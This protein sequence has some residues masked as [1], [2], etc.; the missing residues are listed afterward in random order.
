LRTLLQG[1]REAGI[2]A[3]DMPPRALFAVL[4]LMVPALAR[5]ATPVPYKVPFAIPNAVDLSALADVKVQGW[6]GGRI[7]A[8][9]RGRLLVVDT[10]PLLAGYIKKPGEQPW[11]G[12]HVGKWIDAA[13]LSWAYD[14]N[15]KMKEKLDGVVAQLLATQEADGYLG[16]YIPTQRFGLYDGADWDVWT[17]AYNMIGLMTYY[18]YTGDEAALTAVRRMGDLLVAT[19]PARKSIVAA[20]THEG[21][22]ATSVLE[23][24]VELYRLTGDARYLAFA[25]YIVGAYDEPGGPGIVRSLLAGRGV[26]RTANGKAYEMLANLMGICDMARVTGDRR[27]LEAVANAWTDITRNRLYVTGTASIFEHFSQDHEL[28]NTADDQLGETCVTTTWIQLNL[29]LLEVTGSAAY[30]DEVE[31]SLY[32]HLAAAQNPRGDDWCYYTPLEGRKRYDSGITCCHSSGPRALALAPEAAYL[33]GDGVICVNTLETSSVHAHP[34]GADVELTQASGFPRS[35]QSA[36]TIH[37]VVPARFALRIRVPGWAAPLQ[38]DGK[39]FG[40]G[41]AEVPARVW[42]DNDQVRFTFNLAGRVIPGEYSNYARAAFAWGPFILAA[43]STQNPKINL[44]ES[45]KMNIGVMPRL[46]G[47]GEGLTFSARTKDLWDR[48]ETDIELVPFADAGSSG[49][50]YRVWLRAGG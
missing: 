24:V 9:E 14:G 15:P 26:A 38:V 19:F 35:G 16:T 29:K 48:N 33:Q 47:T 27:L 46:L 37:A 23:P 18:R 2:L 5:S 12:E 42:T 8:N 45:L 3:I 4:V 22:A 43:D 32:N 13:T 20:G 44:L 36:L 40:A 7:D 10:V 50:Q 1:S 17:H 11:I 34:G 21:M 30:A 41:W 31:R 39:D 6:L 25:R 49:G 28:P